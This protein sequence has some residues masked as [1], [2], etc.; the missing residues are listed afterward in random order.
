[1]KMERKIKIFIKKCKIYIYKKVLI[2]LCIDSICCCNCNSSYTN[3]CKKY[4]KRF[5]WVI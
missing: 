1:M 3:R 5:K 2:F 4:I